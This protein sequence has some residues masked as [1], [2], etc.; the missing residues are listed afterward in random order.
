MLDTASTSSFSH[1]R[2]CKSSGFFSWSVSHNPNVVNK[3]SILACQSAKLPV[4]SNL[5]TVYLDPSWTEGAIVLL[6]PL[7][8]NDYPGYRVA[9]ESNITHKARNEMNTRVCSCSSANTA[10]SAAVKW[11]QLLLIA[12]DYNK[13]SSKD[14]L[15]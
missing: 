15:Q 11:S 2:S 3:S 5:S 9:A 8:E 4:P 1:A 13:G 10:T 6:I 7:V 14:W 12:Q